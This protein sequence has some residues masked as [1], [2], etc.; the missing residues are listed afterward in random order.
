MKD[1][2]DLTHQLREIKRLIA[3]GK[4]TERLLDDEIEGYMVSGRIIDG[5]LV[6]TK[7]IDSVEELL[8]WYEV[9]K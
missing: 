6:D 9:A 3:I 1:R 5:K 8:E 2:G 7:A 4:A